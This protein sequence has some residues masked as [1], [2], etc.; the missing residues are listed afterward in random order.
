MERTEGW[1][2][3]VLLNFGAQLDNNYVIILGRLQHLLGTDS[4]LWSSFTITLSEP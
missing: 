3:P 1:D 2:W 4:L